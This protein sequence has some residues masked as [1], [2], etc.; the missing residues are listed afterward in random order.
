MSVLQAWVLFPLVCAVL[1]TGWGLLVDRAA[2][3]TVRTLLLAPLGLAAIVVVARLAMATG[4]TAELAT[5]LVVLGAGAGLWIGRARLG[6]PSG[7]VAWPLAAA[8]AVFA[9][10]AAPI[11]LSGSATFAGYTILGDTAVHFT[12]IDRIA[13][14]GTSLDGLAPSSYQET[15]RNYLGSGYPLGAHAALAALRP[16]AFADVAWLFQPFLAFVA[17]MLALTL[18]ALLR[19]VVRGGWRTA[20]VAALAAQPALVY[21]YS[22]QGSIK[23]IVTLWLVPL[24][25]AAVAGLAER[26]GE[27]PA[28]GFRELLP[29]AVASAA[30]IAAI[31]LAV[32]AWLGPMLLVGLWVVARRGRPGP[33][34]VAALAAGFAAVVALI[35][36]PTLRYA[37]EYLEVAQA[38][39]TAQEEFGNLGGPLP[40]IQ[41]AGIWLT[42]DFRYLPT[43]GPGIDA[44]EA[45]YLLI[46]VAAVAALFG[47]VWL[48][49]RR[50]LGPLLFAASSL[51]ALWYVLRSGS[52]WAD[53]KA[54]AIAS[55]AVLMLAALGPVALEARGARLEAALIALALA[56]G[57]LGSNALAYHDVSLAPRD[58]FEELEQV[59]RFAAGDGPLAYTEFEEFGKHFLRDAQPVGLSEA[60]AVPGLSVGYSDGGAPAFGFPADVRRLDP[61]GLSRFGT[62][63]TRRTP[64]GERP[65]GDWERVWSGRYYDLW[66]NRDRDGG[67]PG[68]AASV[69]CPAPPTLFVAGRPLPGGWARTADEP[70][71]VQTVG[72]GVVDGAVRV[73]APG[74]YSVWVSGS[75]GRDVEVLVG[76]RSV[77]AASDD[78]SQPAAWIELGTVT[79]RP[80]WHDVEL[81]RGGGSLA[82][83]NGDGPRRV[84]A[85]V[86]RPLTAAGCDARAATSADPVS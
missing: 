3:G 19:G 76:G 11:A 9:I 81:V 65:P 33:G 61:V 72:P 41:V 32:A 37:S 21:A 66:R 78:L 17:A 15:L 47:V 26:R 23:E 20:A 28:V 53:A 69:A 38:V 44:L 34:R 52:P 85:V 79:L 77:G 68:Q 16:L 75:F 54:L 80:G 24:I 51:I 30:G 4:A 71:L 64:F 67:R 13:E 5:P 40:L 49:R 83:G 36:L 1:A 8:V 84:G 14:H 60:F 10:Y 29:L 50:A 45:T 58:R 35:S 46:G 18:A 74:R 82:P 22:L 43:S 73:T 31:G 7:E 70:P 55:P 57:V 63:V 56:G 6:R 2:G 59:E 48:V 27:R 39:V 12:L 86:L 62:L 25:A 42:G